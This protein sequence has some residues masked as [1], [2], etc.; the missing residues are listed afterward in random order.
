M[1]RLPE[2]SDS[3]TCQERYKKNIY[4]KWLAM[5]R[6]A[7]LTLNDPPLPQLY[8]QHSQSQAHTGLRALIR[9]SMQAPVSVLVRRQ[10]PPSPPNPE[11][12]PKY[13]TKRLVLNPGIS[14]DVLLSLPAHAAWKSTRKSSTRHREAD[15]HISSRHSYQNC[16]PDGKM[17]RRS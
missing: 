7:A 15:Y 8:P 14:E 16:W 9:T 5:V 1:S 17:A 10:K 4:C 11:W 12:K 2:N 6:P 3:G 13:H